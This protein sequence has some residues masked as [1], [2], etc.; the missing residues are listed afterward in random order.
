MHII[1][2]IIYWNNLTLT[3]MFEVDNESLKIPKRCLLISLIF[4]LN[5]FFVSS[6]TSPNKTRQHTHL[7]FSSFS[8]NIFSGSL[9]SAYVLKHEQTR[10]VVELGTLCK[11]KNYENPIPTQ[12]SYL[13]WSETSKL[14]SYF[15][16][17]NLF[18][19][20]EWHAVL[21]TKHRHYL[22][23]FQTSF[24]SARHLPSFQLRIP[25]IT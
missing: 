23:V 24:Y 13:G 15:F 2:K 5:L 25:E 9:L 19:S 8:A 14:P 17:H 21:K 10:N 7:G 1:F 4:V 11:E 6:L 18:F 16:L 3:L 22:T 20:H 12:S